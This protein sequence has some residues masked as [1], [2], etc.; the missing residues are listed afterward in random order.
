MSNR[1]KMRFTEISFIYY[2]SPGW[3]RGF[4]VLRPEGQSY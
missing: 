3:C 1:E 4:Y 2:K